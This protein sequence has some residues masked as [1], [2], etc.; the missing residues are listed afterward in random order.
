MEFWSDTIIAITAASGA[1]GLLLTV[2]VVLAFTLTPERARS[3][4]TVFS[5]IA[6]LVRGNRQII[7]RVEASS[8]SLNTLYNDAVLYGPRRA[9]QTA[10]KSV[11]VR[12]P[13]VAP[14]RA[15]PDAVYDRARPS[16]EAVRASAAGGLARLAA[17]VP[18]RSRFTRE[19]GTA[20]ANQTASGF[21]RPLPPFR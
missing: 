7:E 9:M 10:A 18:P 1:V 17:D 5:S 3:L 21:N 19:Q 16:R 4:G 6:Q 14:Y 20:L 8:R 2:I 11:G 12:P 15:R 13:P